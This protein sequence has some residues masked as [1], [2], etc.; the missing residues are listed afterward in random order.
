VLIHHSTVA[1]GGSG[2]VPFALRLGYY[3]SNMHAYGRF[4]EVM[5]TWLLSPNQS[6]FMCLLFF[7]GG[8]FTPSS[9]ERKG[10][11][12]FVRDKLQ[13]LGWPLVVM[14]FVVSPLSAAFRTAILIGVDDLLP[15]VSFSVSVT[16]FL[17]TLLIFSISY[18]ILPFPQV[19]V[20]MP[21]TA[22]VLLACAA[23]GAVQGWVLYCNFSFIGIFPIING[24]LPF[25]VAF[26][27]AGCLAKRSGW[28]EVIQGMAPRDFWL[29]RCAAL[30]TVVGNGLVYLG[31]G[32]VASSGAW[33]S[34]LGSATKPGYV[35]LT[36]VCFGVMTGGISVSVLHFFAVHC[37]SPSHWQ[38]LAGQSQY[39][40]Y[41][42]QVVVIPGVMLT[43]LPILRAAGYPVEFEGG[44]DW[45]SCSTE[46]PEGVIVG[47]WLYTIVLVTLISWPLGYFF[48]KLPLVRDVL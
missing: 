25:D 17:K 22:Q 14:Y 16:W 35:V 38:S 18:A 10:V 4:G 43:L 8:V 11:A 27:A 41:V 34:G 42:L 7:V 37:N 45:Y 15:Y 31:T 36:G 30:V 33:L 48:R 2:D 40:V 5:T 13:R 1:F 32:Y 47:G 39:A 19:S 21:S 23:L 44:L 6:F 24:G 9:L 46:L 29:A 3:D 28:L 12:E 26:F 20:P